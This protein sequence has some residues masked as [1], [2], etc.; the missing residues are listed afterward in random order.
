MKWY[1]RPLIPISLAMFVAT[2]I[3]ISG[4][5]YYIPLLAVVTTF[6]GAVGTGSVSCLF[7]GRA[8]RVNSLV[9]IL[10]VA[11]MES[12]MSLFVTLNYDFILKIPLLGK[13]LN[14]YE[15]MARKL[16]EKKKFVEGL[17]LYTIFIL[18][19]IPWYGTGAITMSLVG[20]ILSLE[21]KKVWATISLASLIRTALIVSL[22]YL[23]LLIQ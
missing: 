4:P 13:L 12:D 5:D 3:Y 14:R 18:M 20:R 6:F 15:G 23:G 1:L 22:L 7:V 16:L 2:L 11:F 8:L 21:W 17:E 9:L 10:L 19:F